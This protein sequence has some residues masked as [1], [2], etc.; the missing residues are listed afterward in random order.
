MSEERWRA[1]M[2]DAAKARDVYLTEHINP[3]WR[4]WFEAQADDVKSAVTAFWQDTETHQDISASHP[5]SGHARAA[6]L[7]A[8]CADNYGYDL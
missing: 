1:Q 4:K 3:V 7:I 6:M 5:R 2:E 8:W